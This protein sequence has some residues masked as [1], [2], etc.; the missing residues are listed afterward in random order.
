M[1][2]TRIAAIPLRQ[3]YLLKGSAAR[4]I[5]LFGWVVIDM[6]LWGFM[7][8]FLSGLG[9][10]PYRFVPALLGAVLF[11][12]FMTRVMMGITTAFFEDVWSRNFLNLFSSP[13][14]VAEYI[15]GLLITSI[16]TGLVGLVA[17]AAV[18]WAFFGLSI[19]TYG[20]MMIPFILVLMI[21][22]MA[23]GVVAIAVVLRLG[24]AAEW[25]VWPI[26]ALL[27]PFAAVYYPLTT[28]PIAM[29]WL[30]K[31][32]PASYVFE[33]MRAVVAGHRFEVAELWLAFVLAAIYLSVAYWIFTRVFR[34]AIRQGLITRY[35]SQ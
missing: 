22:G 21:F 10:T 6:V 3:V 25:F 33:G 13:I 16:S 4:I 8:R 5:P 7:T 14:T 20:V 19:A 9:Q 1:N 24:P 12:D 34:F 23:L 35:M 29:R 30:A 15:A 2:L 18:A 31:L 32:M 27:A 28:L 17:G 26:P 11:W